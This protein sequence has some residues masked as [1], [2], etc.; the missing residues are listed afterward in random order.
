[1]ASAPCAPAVQ[2]TSAGPLALVRAGGRPVPS[3]RPPPA[4]AGLTDSWVDYLIAQQEDSPS[5]VPV[6]ALSVA[7]E[8]VEVA[9]AEEVERRAS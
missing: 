5:K 9:A 3:A 6:A 8:E 2:L 7:E 1:M 4:G